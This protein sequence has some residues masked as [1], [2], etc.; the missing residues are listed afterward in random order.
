MRTEDLSIHI[1]R[2]NFI[3]REPFVLTYRR[4]LEIGGAAAAVCLFLFGMQFGRVHL[5]EARQE[6]LEKEVQALREESDRIFKQMSASG[7]PQSARE[8]LTSLF[9]KA[10]PWAALLKEMTAEAP[11]SV[12]LTGLKSKEGAGGAG[13]IGLQLSGHSEEAGSVAQFLKSLTASSFFQNVVLASSKHE[14]V[15]GSDVYSFV[16]DLSVSSSEGK[17]L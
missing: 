11:R 5:A 13:M 15:S 14:M 8:A 6:R 9:E 16:I 7:G 4:M 12:W 17:G 3:E 2:I 10:P 1:Q